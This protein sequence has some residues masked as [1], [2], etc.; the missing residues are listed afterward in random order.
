MRRLHVSLRR[1]RA[2]ADPEAVATLL[3]KDETSAL[4]TTPATL[5][6]TAKS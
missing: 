2:L 6:G 5:Y 1:L 3:A 4:G